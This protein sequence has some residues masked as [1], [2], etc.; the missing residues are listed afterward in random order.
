MSKTLSEQLGVYLKDAY[1]I[2]QQSLQQLKSAPDVAGE[3][4][5]AQALRDHLAETEGHARQIRSLLEQRGESPS[6]FKNAVMR[7]GGSAFVLFARVQPD[8]PG[9]L[10]AHA[11]SYEALEWAAYDLLSRTAER[12]GDA[13]AAAVARSIRDEERSMMNRI[14]GLFDRTVEA[15]LLPVPQHKLRDALCAYLADAHAIETQSIQLLQS[16]RKTVADFPA[17]AGL[18]GKHLEQ[19]RN[20]QLLL[21]QR[22]EAL[23]GA[24][25]LI[26]DAALRLGALNWSAFF[27]GQPDTAGKLTAFA[28]A[29]EH[30]EI[31]GYEQLRRVAQRV[32]DAATAEIAE[33]IL[34]EERGMGEE[35]ARLFDEAVSAALVERG[36]S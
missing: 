4:A 5:F 14:E 12:A 31:G 16:G 9:K 10:A 36:I 27:L 23:G 22:L 19:S 26:K 29:F 32:N 18:F 30:L 34:V 20:Q 33:R 13:E 6:W 1:A 15:S 3:P 7:A 11:L 24:R 35:L 8:T 25:S 28:Y 17:I 21:E 2:E